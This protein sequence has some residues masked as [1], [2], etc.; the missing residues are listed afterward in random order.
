MSKEVS[1]LLKPTRIKLTVRRSPTL[2]KLYFRVAHMRHRARLRGARWRDGLRGG[3]RAGGVN[4]E[5]MIW[6]F[7]TARSGS[8][9]LRSMLNEIVEGEVWE[10]PKVGRLFGEFYT[11]AKQTQLGRVNYV[12]GDPTREA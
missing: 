7:C 4:P 10:E 11:R 1:K 6:I 5:N 3:G 9:W 8:T 12:L 2:R